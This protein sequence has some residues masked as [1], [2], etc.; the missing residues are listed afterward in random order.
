VSRDAARRDGAT[1]DGAGELPGE[2]VWQLFRAL[3]HAGD[4]PIA[5]AAGA[6]ADEQTLLGDAGREQHGTRVR[7]AL[8]V[9][10]RRVLEARYRA[11]GCPYTLAACEWLARQLQG[12]ELAAPAAAGLAQVVGGPLDWA[13]TLQIPAARLGR[14]LVIEDALRAAF[15]PRVIKGA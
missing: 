2:A 1:R 13:R 9:A 3:Q 12:R 8:R 6:A 15:D 11:F 14:L 5:G 4:L 10:G 7:F